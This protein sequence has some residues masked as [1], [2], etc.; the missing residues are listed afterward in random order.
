MAVHVRQLQFIF[1]VRHRT[2]AAHR[3]IGIL[4]SGKVRHQL[5]EAQHFHI[6][7]MRGDLRRQRHALIQAE[8]RLFA[9]AGGDGQ[10]HVI[11]HQ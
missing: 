6:V 10:N 1:K 4:V 11:E 3:D 5:A 7:Q 9:R 8:Q 2:Q